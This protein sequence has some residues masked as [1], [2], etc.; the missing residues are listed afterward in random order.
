MGA[1]LRRHEV[2]FKID[3]F[4]FSEFSVPVDARAHVSSYNGIKFSRIYETL[5]NYC[6]YEKENETAVAVAMTVMDLSKFRE[7]GTGQASTRL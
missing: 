3:R 7:S 6:Q 5:L 4:T 2:A 1:R